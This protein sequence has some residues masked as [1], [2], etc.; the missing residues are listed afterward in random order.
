L[1]S[2]D[3]NDGGLAVVR[4][5]TQMP[6]FVWRMVNQSIKG[7]VLRLDWYECDDDQ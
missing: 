3:R 5:A 1:H 7:L 2:R 4:N 6:Q